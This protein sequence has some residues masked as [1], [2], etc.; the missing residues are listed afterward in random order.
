[1]GLVWCTHLD[2]AMIVIGNGLARVGTT[3]AFE[4]TTDVR[5]MLFAALKT[6]A[7]GGEHTVDCRSRTL[8]V[9]ITFV[10]RNCAIENLYA[11]ARPTLSFLS[12]D[13]QRP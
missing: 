9:D 2:N 13:R 4:L 6:H 10:L 5:V 3:V 8:S 11:F 1:M 12:Q 7:V